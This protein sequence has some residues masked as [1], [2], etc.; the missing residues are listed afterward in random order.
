MTASRGQHEFTIL[1][2]DCATAEGLVGGKAL[3]LAKLHGAG[4]PVPAGFAVTTDAYSESVT[5]CELGAQIQQVLDDSS[6]T[7]ETMSQQIDALFSEAV[8]SPEVARAVANSYEQL[9]GSRVDLPVAVRSSATAEDLANASFAGQQETYL[10]VSGIDAILQRLKDCWASLF[11]ARAIEYRWR[12]AVHIDNLAMGAVIQEMVDAEAAGVMMTLDPASGD[13]STIYLESAYGLGESVVR[14]EVS[15]DRLSIDKSTL[16]IRSFETGDKPTMWTPSANGAP[17]RVDVPT[18][19]RNAASITRREAEELAEIGCRVEKAFGAPMDIEWAVGAADRAGN[20]PIFMLQA[21]PE[22]VWSMRTD[23]TR[24]L[25]DG[26][27]P[28][29]SPSDPNLHWATSNLGEAC[30]GVLTPLSWSV[31]QPVV[32]RSAR[33]AAFA[34]GALTRRE[35]RL[36]AE[37]GDRYIR[38]FK[39]RPAM[40][41][42]FMAMLGD[43][44]PGT[45]GAKTISGLFGHVPE[46]IRF[47]PTRRRYPV[48]AWRLPFSFLTI[49][50]RIARLSNQTNIWWRARIRELD[51]ANLTQ[52]LAA[53]VDARRQLDEAVRLQSILNLSTIQPLWDALGAVVKKAGVGD[54][55]VLGGFGGPEMDV[56]GD[57]CAVANGQDEL[58]TVVAAHGFHGPMEGELSSTVWRENDAPLRRL[59]ASY[60]EKGPQAD[61]RAHRHSKAHQLRRMQRTVLDSLPWTKRL[62]ALLVLRLAAARLPKRGVPKRAFLQALD[63]A[64]AAA[65]CAGQLL[66]EQGLLR[67]PSDVFYLTASELCNELP[68]NVEELVIARRKRRAEYLANSYPTEWQGEPVAIPASDITSTTLAEIGVL[69]GLGVSSGLVEGQVRVV[70]DP[71]S[72]EVRTGD[73]VVAPTTDPSWCSVMFVSSALVVDIGGA[74]S[75]ASVVARELGIPCVVNTRTGTQQLQTGDRVRVDGDSGTVELIAAASDIDYEHSPETA[76]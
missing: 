25:P 34:I 31:W 22:T 55:S 43:R 4:F 47:H 1:L 61:P 49:G 60:R 65:R 19:L 32:E 27:D 37:V 20:R 70:L 69:N 67:D 71:A 57:M 46:G 68:C 30:P 40:Q 45:S 63:V 9:C 54:F 39:G 72:A 62:G 26:W 14:G 51:R 33:E 8:V 64:R 18:G 15:P 29:D 75:H 11:T 76:L 48:V 17:A 2:P 5:N 7:F 44:L 73:I 53:F 28:L 10:W 59:L 74:L 66:S 41:V 58:T 35:R 36:P 13:R 52:A 21:R 38:I 23:A 16:S 24:S 50:G 12:M 6:I 56:V 42:E 3:G